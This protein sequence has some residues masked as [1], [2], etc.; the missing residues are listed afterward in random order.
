[1]LQSEQNAKDTQEM[2]SRLFPN[3]HWINID[4]HIF[5]AAS[6][7]P[8]SGRQSEILTQELLQSR[9]LA[10]FGHTIYLLPEFGPRKTKHPDAI[11][12]GLIMEF[13]TISGNE[14][15][16]KEKYKEAREKAENVFL[17]INPSFSHR[18]VARKLAGSIRGKGYKS[19]LI[20]VY[21]THT[22]KMAYWTVSGLK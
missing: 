11:V 3:E 16:I 18:T 5:M 13:K 7:A 12:D 9:I 22:E 14:R 19:G 20:W 21:F 15:K 6:R 4:E 1:M 8:R 17:Q 2:A 10:S